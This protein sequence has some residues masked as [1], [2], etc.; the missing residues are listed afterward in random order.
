MKKLFL[1]ISILFVSAGSVYAESNSSAN[2]PALSQE[3]IQAMYNQAVREA[4]TP[5]PQQQPIP[6]SNPP[7]PKSFIS[8][9]Q[10]GNT[11]AIVKGST[12]KV[13]K[14]ILVNDS[15]SVAVKDLATALGI[16]DKNVIYY[17]QTKSVRINVN[18]QR[19]TLKIGSKKVYIDGEEKSYAYAPVM[20]KGTFYVP[21]RMLA[22]VLNVKVEWYPHEYRVLLKQEV[23]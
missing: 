18:S 10:L 22:E 4:Q 8:E 23:Q 6:P 9:F 21:V 19:I 3:Q 16:P 7:E 15:F 2:I 1:T 14:P 20:Y 11:N 13:S 17:P 5:Q 12:K